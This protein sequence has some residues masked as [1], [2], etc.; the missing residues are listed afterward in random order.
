VRLRWRLAWS[1]VVMRSAPRPGFWLPLRVRPK[2]RQAPGTHPET[3]GL[4]PPKVP[5]AYPVSPPRKAARCSA[6]RRSALSMV[7]SSR[8][9]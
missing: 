3:P 6:S 9:L 5:R 1:S 2:P 8:K 7:S 4:D